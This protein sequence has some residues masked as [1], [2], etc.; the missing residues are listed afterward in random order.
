MSSME[1][2]FYIGVD[3]SGEDCGAELFFNAPV[4]K[5]LGAEFV[6]Y[7]YRPKLSVRQETEK[8]YML[9][10]R[11]EENGIYFVIN[12]ETG[13][14]SETL[15]STDG[16]DWVTREDG[17]HRFKFPRQVL[18]A[19]ASSKMFAGV[20]Y[21]EAE[22]AQLFRNLS[23]GMEGGTPDLPF[24]PD[25]PGLDLRQTDEHICSCAKELVE[26]NMSLGAPRVMCEYVWPSLMHNFARAGMHIAYKQQKENWSNIWAAIAMGAARQ[27]GCELWAC[28]D[29]WFRATYPGHSAAEMASNLLFAYRTGID[30]VYVEN[31]GGKNFYT[32]QPD[33][34]FILGEFGKYYK[35][36]VDKYIAPCEREYSHLDFEPDIAIIRFDDTFWGQGKNMPWKDMLFGNPE[37]KSSERS[38][39]WL[40][41][42]H[43]I[44]HGAV[45]QKSLSWG[46]WDVYLSDAHRSFAPAKG[47]IVYDDKARYNDL[48]TAKLLFLCGEFIGDE[49]LADA[50]TLV[51]EGAT[52]VTSARFAPAG[53]TLGY[54]GGT[55]TVQDEKGKWV[56]TDDMAS[57]EVKAEINELLGEPDEMTFNFKGG[58]TVRF[59]I[60]ADGNEL[61][62]L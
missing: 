49:T 53:I 57:D 33:G 10:K 38:G 42:W 9:A 18:E 4:A 43:T 60:S 51:R 50:G 58:R 34:S 46:R 61:T 37:H 40:K 7:H 54:T 24:F 2:N 22:H 5:E 45:K 15:T 17:G 13:N 14:W 23:I 28:V 59:K 62:E 30:R 20:L 21:D 19:F 48:K 47:P 32:M 6:V 16:Y 52:A 3:N 29:L 11:F 8:A 12:T 27:Y 41:A 39:E 44:T 31:S 56:I 26:E 25:A 55:A 36:I 35:E 1:K